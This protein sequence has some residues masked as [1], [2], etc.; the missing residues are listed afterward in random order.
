MQQTRNFSEEENKLFRRILESKG[1]QKQAAIKELIDLRLDEEN[2]VM[3]W[4][5]RTKSY[6]I[7]TRLKN[8]NS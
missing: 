5:N 4:L 6:D 7:Y 3:Q 8:E 2:V 1:D